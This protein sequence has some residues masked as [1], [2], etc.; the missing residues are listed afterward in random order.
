[1]A[2]QD[3][4]RE[5]EMRD[6]FGLSENS[7]RKRSDVDAVLKVSH[8]VM[9]FELKSTTV[10][11]FSTVRDLGPEHII[12]WDKMHW[13]LAF[14]DKTGRTIKK[15]Y[16]GSPRQMRPWVSQIAEYI[17]PDQTLAQ[18]MSER[19]DKEVLNFVV[20]PGEV[21]TLDDASRIQKRQW[22]KADYIKNQDLTDG[23]SREKMQ[24]ILKSRVHY[25]ISRGSTLN[26]PHIPGNYVRNLTE[27]SLV[28]SEAAQ[29]LLSAVEAELQK[30][31]H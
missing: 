10:S 3:D 12:K 9:D 5:S 15:A 14:Y 7:G 8:K 1:M 18:L 25:L 26:N 17:K 31:G 24:E 28:E 16:Y 22:S 11:S 21:F 27:L 2:I 13:L 6:F 19:V 20:G 23:Y 4:S 30:S 29:S